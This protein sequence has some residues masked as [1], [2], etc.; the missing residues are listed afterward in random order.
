MSDNY[1]IPDFMQAYL[2]GSY[3]FSKTVLNLGGLTLLR[4][5]DKVPLNGDDGSK[6]EIQYFHGDMLGVCVGI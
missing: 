5:E 1:F 2:E 4:V 3:N 6:K